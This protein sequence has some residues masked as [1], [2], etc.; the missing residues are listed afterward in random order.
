MASPTMKIVAA[1]ALAATVLAVAAAA[2]AATDTK[3]A[4]AP[5]RELAFRKGNFIYTAREDG[6]A[7]R[8]I[9]RGAQPAYSPDGR[10]I[11]FVRLDRIYVASA[12]GRNERRL[13]NGPGDTWPAW[14][15]DGKRIAF[16][17]RRTGEFEVY[18]M[19]ADGTGVKRL[20]FRK[21]RDEGAHSPAWS[22]DGRLIAF[23]SNRPTLFN[24]EI[25]VMRLDGTGVKRLTYTRGSDAEFG[26]DGFPSWAPNAKAIVF[27]SNR[28]QDG[29]MWTMQPTGRGQ[30]LLHNIKG[31]D[32]WYP[33]VSP[34]GRRI[35][36]QRTFADGVDEVWVMAANGTGA[37]RIGLGGDPTWRPAVRAAAVE[38]SV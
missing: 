37:R 18:V 9:T 19:N 15:P 24:P 21:R 13:T 20:T 14:S 32:E 29:A 30:R 31:T 26:D 11:A 28:T 5:V 35:A 23:A 1:A 3:A 27:S 17:S 2:P 16:T 34:D 38:R 8:R 10:R 25:Y 4:G 22:P 7:L 33:R 6:S 12:D 36:F